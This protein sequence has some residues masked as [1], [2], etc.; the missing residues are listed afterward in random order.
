MIK[1]AVFDLDN[2][3]YDYDKCDRYAMN[4]LKNSCM[5]AYGISAGKFEAL[6]GQAKK[7][8]KGRLGD[9]AASHNR[10][11]YVQNFLE[12][13]KEKPAGRALELYGIYWDAML[14]RME[15]YG[16]V[17]PLLQ[18]LARRKIRTAVL[19]DLTAHIQHRKIR[20]LGIA[21]YVDVLVTSEE[22]GKEKPDGAAFGLVLEKLK[23]PP[24]QVVMIGD[25]REKDIRGAE[26]AGMHGIL[27]SREKECTVM[28]ECLELIGYEA[29]RE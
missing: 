3:I 29:E 25:S 22:A 23:L 11:L 19:T 20:K 9:A 13:L 6:Y 12:L 5:D 4:V 28:Q 27:Y 8:V 14:E 2:T 17:L 1:A 7:A 21:Q 15:P 26:A 18:E 16:Y 10:M 24:G